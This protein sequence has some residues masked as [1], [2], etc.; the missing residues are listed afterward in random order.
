VLA[1]GRDTADAGRGRSP[2]GRALKRGVLH[3]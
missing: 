3:D 1:L 2:L